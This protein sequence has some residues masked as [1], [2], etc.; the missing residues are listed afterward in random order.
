MPLEFFG[1]WLV[2]FCGFSCKFNAVALNS[3]TV[4]CPLTKNNS[5]S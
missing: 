4:R 5:S 2:F 1:G 3:V